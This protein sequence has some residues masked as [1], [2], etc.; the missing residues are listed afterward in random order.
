M[1]VY[2]FINDKY[3]LKDLAE[4]HLKI[5]RIMEINDPFE[6]LGVDLSDRD[7]RRAMKETKE[8]LSKSNGL[9]CFSKNWK[10]P[11]LWGHYA[12]KH[13]GIALGSTCRSYH[14]RK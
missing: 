7:F 10:N 14:Q 3:G 5:A 12:D 2:H 13:R 11:V 6:F 1:R 8:D 9:L 4:R